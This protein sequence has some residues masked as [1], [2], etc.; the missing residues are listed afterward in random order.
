MKAYDPIAM[1]ESR[2]RIGDTIEYA[3]D[4]YDAT[5]DAN[6]LM[7][8]N[9]WKEFRLTSWFILKKTMNNT[10]VFDGRNIYD[11]SVLEVSGFDYYGIG[12]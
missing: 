7:V 3:A 8:V 6:A 11:R 4:M 12:Y 1:E 2:R 9:E 10:V 5:L